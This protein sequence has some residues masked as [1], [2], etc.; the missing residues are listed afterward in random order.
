MTKPKRKP[1]TEP[2]QIRINNPNWEI[3]KQW[4]LKDGAGFCFLSNASR[5]NLWV[6]ELIK[7]SR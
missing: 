7:K 5:F 3:Y 1:K 4:C 6:S 2:F